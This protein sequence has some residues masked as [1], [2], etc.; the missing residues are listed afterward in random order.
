MLTAN[1]ATHE[2]AGA[3]SVDFKTN[4]T[5]GSVALLVNARI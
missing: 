4:P 1:N 3:K 2:R 5:N